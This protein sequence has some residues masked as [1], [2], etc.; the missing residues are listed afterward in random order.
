LSKDLNIENKITFI[1]EL[2]NKEVKELISS[3]KLYVITS[4]RE[5][6]SYTFAESLVLK[7]PLLST[8]V[9]D[10]KKT[11]GE[12]YIVPFDDP[13]KLSEKIE[14]IKLNYDIILKDF[15]ASF[16]FAKEEFNI[17]KMVDKTIYTYRRLST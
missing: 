14:S 16:C 13:K 4:Q 10:I 1:E 7:T 17:S 2:E 15:K 12:K 5:G 3:S 9:A 8:D 11:I 6:F